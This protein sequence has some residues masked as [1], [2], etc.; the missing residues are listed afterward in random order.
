[1]PELKFTNQFKH[2]FVQ[3]LENYFIE[4]KINLG[5]KTDIDQ[6]W[7]SGGLN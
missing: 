7:G 4:S 5:V 1:V 3:G 2:K 6:Y